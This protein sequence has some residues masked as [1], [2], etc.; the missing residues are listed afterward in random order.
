MEDKKL[1]PVIVGL[2]DELFSTTEVEIEDVDAFLES[3]G[4]DISTV[5]A[6]FA[7]SAKKGLTKKHLS[8]AKK[9]QTLLVRAKEILEQK[10]SEGLLVIED[11][12][13]LVPS[14]SLVLHNRLK[15]L[16]KEDALQILEQEELLKLIEELEGKNAE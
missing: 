2:I 6:Q 10:I 11:L 7:L 1:N 4:F 8:K 9:R 14:R 12:P 16:N 3:S 15:E 13:S 5:G